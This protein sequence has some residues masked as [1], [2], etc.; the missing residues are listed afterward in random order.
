VNGVSLGTSVFDNVHYSCVHLG[1]LQNAVSSRA[2]AA[3]TAADGDGVQIVFVRCAE[4]VSGQYCV[5]C[6]LRET[7][8]WCAHVTDFEMGE[9]RS[10]Q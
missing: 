6:A 1:G 10:T 7:V 2:Q 3:A 5:V 8:L 9:L 4:R